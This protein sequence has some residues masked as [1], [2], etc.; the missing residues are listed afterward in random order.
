MATHPAQT[1]TDTPADLVAALTLITGNYT[2]Q[3]I[4][5]EPIWFS[6]KDSAVGDLD[7]LKAEGGN[8]LAAPFGGES[9]RPD[10]PNTAT[11]S[12]A[13]DLVYVWTGRGASR[14]V[15]SDAV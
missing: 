9:R 1:I 2:L 5:E 8:L 13:G 14:L 7:V 12:V 15:V 10:S 11:I 3:N 6:Q 4:G